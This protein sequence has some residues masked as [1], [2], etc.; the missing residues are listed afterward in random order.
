[1]D[2]RKSIRPN[3]GHRES[4][5]EWKLKAPHCKGYWLRVNAGHRVELHQIIEIDG[6]PSI[7]W[8]WSGSQALISIVDERWVDK[9]GSFWWL[10]PLP[11]P[12][13]NAL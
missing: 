11:D 1:M 8:G 3:N 9:L 13:E 5:L 4:K 2:T 6:V 10:G 7:M 12:P